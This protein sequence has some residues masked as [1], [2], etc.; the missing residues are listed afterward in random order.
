MEFIKKQKLGFMV[1]ALVA[2][3]IIV[4]LIVYAANVN[5][6]YYKDMNTTVVIM[7]VSALVLVL[8][9]LVIPQLS[10]NVIAKLLTDICRVGAAV[11]IVV[12]GA[13]FLG[14]RVESFGYIFGSNLELG[15]EAAF[16]AG[17]QAITGIVLFVITWILSLIAAFLEI[18]K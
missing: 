7:T 6:A 16:S 12:A 2:V 11:L 10:Q 9:A 13:T 8:A 17:S 14:M 5:A 3:M 18:R 4:S 1:N 15:N